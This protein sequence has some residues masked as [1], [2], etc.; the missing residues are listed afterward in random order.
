M[1][2]NVRCVCLTCCCAVAAVTPQLLGAG[3]LLVY[4]RAEDSFTILPLGS[5][6][7]IISYIT[8]SGSLGLFS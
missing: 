5:A 6:A 2:Y 8:E 4:I 1:N 7:S 3:S